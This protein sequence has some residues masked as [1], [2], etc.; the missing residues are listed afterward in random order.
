LSVARDEFF[1]DD[2]IKRGPERTSRSFDDTATGKFLAASTDSAAP[3]LAAL[4]VFH[5]RAALA[6]TW[7]LVDPR[8]IDHRKSL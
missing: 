8:R 1:P 3:R 7:N 5:L 2:V 6:V 4:G